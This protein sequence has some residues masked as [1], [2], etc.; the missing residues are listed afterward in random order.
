MVVR[1]HGPVFASDI[2]LANV[3]SLSEILPKP[4]DIV[5]DGEGDPKHL[6][7]WM[8]LHNRGDQAVDIVDCRPDDAP[9]AGSSLPTSHRAPGYYPTPTSSSSV[10]RPAPY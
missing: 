4:H 1:G 5:W 9:N 2:T 10:A 3:L 6:D 8:E 7:E